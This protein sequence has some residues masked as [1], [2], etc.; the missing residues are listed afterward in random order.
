MYLRNWIMQPSL[1]YLGISV[2]TIDNYIKYLSGAPKDWITCCFRDPWFNQ[3]N[4]T[5]IASNE[6]L[7]PPLSARKITSYLFNE[8]NYLEKKLLTLGVPVFKTLNLIKTK[9]TKTIVN[10]SGYFIE[11]IFISLHKT[12]ANK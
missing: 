12:S 6:G 3:T 1:K 8:N 7:P 11:K 9:T 2:N 4:I 5:A 10:F